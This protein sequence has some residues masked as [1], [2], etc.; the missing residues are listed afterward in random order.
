MVGSHTVGTALERTRA[1]HSFSERRAGSGSL[2]RITSTSQ[3]DGDLCAGNGTARI[4]RN[5]LDLGTG[6]SRTA[7]GLGSSG[8][9]ESTQSVRCAAQRTAMRVMRSQIGRHPVLVF[10]YEGKRVNQLSTKAWYKALARAG[11]ENFRFHDLRHTWASWHVQNG[12]PA[13][14]SPGA[15]RMG[16]RENGATLRAPRRGSPRGL[17]RQVGKLWHKHGTTTTGCYREVTRS[18]A[19]VASLWVEPCVAGFASLCA[20]KRDASLRRF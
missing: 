6:R 2:A 13:L 8:P 16:D 3:S 12:T 11:I 9:S 20:V 17:R 7:D 14:C 1:T 18:P 15:C 19:R 10:E 5:G 4:Q